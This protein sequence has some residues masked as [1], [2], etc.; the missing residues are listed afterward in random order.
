MEALYLACT[1][2]DVKI[3]VDLV[4]ELFISLWVDSE[5]WRW[6]HIFALPI[7]KLNDLWASLKFMQLAPGIT[8]QK[9]IN[10]VWKWVVTQV[11]VFS[12][13]SS[14]RYLLKGSF[15]TN[16]VELLHHFQVFDSW[17]S[18]TYFSENTVFKTWSKSLHC[19]KPLLARWTACRQ[20]HWIKPL[21]EVITE[22]RAS[23]NCKFQLGLHQLWQKPMR[24]IV[25]SVLQTV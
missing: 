9:R 24:V 8:L 21:T 1:S 12:L 6:R 22:N 20:E 25:L 19:N 3:Y 4:W 16:P 13:I 10:F 23:V 17:N 5:T 18:V 14:P 11:F 2:R 7:C 15:Q